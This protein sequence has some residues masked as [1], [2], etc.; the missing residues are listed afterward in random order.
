MPEKVFDEKATE[1]LFSAISKGDTAVALRALKEGADPNARQGDPDNSPMIMAVLYHQPVVTQ[2][3][4]ERGA[5]PDY[6]RKGGETALM[7]A[8]FSNDRASAVLIVEAGANI[9]RQTDYNEDAMMR[10][11][12]EGNKD[13]M[14]LIEETAKKRDKRIADET[15]KR[16]LQQNILDIVSAMESG[17]GASVQVQK[18]LKLRRAHG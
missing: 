17:L 7:M 18:P 14:T 11:S 6:A 5:D 8:A 9:W 1:R 2:A 15:A 10:A 4:L 3:L 12:R 13:M 16:E